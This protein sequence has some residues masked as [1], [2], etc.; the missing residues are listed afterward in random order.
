MAGPTLRLFRDHQDWYSLQIPN[1]FQIQDTD[2]A[3]TQYV[4]NTYGATHNENI[5]MMNYGPCP[6]TTLCIIV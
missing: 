1:I 4:S 2:S 5:M 3:N 6:M